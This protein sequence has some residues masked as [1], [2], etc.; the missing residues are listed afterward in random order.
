MG[1][2]VVFDV[3]YNYIN[4]LGVFSK[5][6]LDKVVLGYYYCYEVDIGV[7]VCE[8]CCD[9]IEFCNVMMEKFMEDLLLMWI[10]YYKYDL[11]CF[12]IMS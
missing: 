3:V 12:D 5:L 6:V 2:C 1:L 10:E 4:V 9:D 7:I 8:M 11:F